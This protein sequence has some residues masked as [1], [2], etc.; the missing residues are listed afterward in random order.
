MEYILQ[1][2]SK[3]N[4]DIDV[5]LELIKRENMVIKKFGNE[6]NIIITEEAN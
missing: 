2:D 4:E 1:I 5:F 6:V 3:T